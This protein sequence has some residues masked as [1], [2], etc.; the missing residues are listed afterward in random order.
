MPWEDMEIIT[1]FQTLPLFF[2]FS[3]IRRF[4]GPAHGDFLMGSKMVKSMIPPM[5]REYSFLPA[6]DRVDRL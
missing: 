2:V 1:V 4:S 3:Q 5:R 6:A